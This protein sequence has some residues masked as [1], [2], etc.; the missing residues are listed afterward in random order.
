MA[1]NGFKAEEIG[2]VADPDAVYQ[3]I[4]D[5]YIVDDHGCDGQIFEITVQGDDN[6]EI[7]GEVLCI[8]SGLPFPTDLQNR[9]IV[10]SV[11]NGHHVS[12]KSVF[13][14]SI[15]PMTHIFLAI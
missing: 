7:T 9:F 1:I 11:P 14:H 5:T 15:I 8:E 12:G 13:R 3:F 2:D 6:G 4:N 10:Q